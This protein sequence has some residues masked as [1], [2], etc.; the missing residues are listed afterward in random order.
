MFL[1]HVP[2]RRPFVLFSHP[3]WPGC[4]VA[5]LHLTSPATVDSL[6]IEQEGILITPVQAMVL[7][8]KHV[9]VTENLTLEVPGAVGDT[10][11][12]RIVVLEAP[13]EVTLVR[14]LCFPMAEFISIH[15]G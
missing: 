15:A 3:R 12:I 11:L 6:V 8:I 10:C 2:M 9:L 4:I 13:L 14:T 7:S 1:C 5:A